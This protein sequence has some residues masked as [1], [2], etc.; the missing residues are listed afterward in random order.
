MEGLTAQQV[1]QRHHELVVAHH[2][3]PGAT[4]SAI[5]RTQSSAG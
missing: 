5:L 1:Y 3:L 2:P 4:T